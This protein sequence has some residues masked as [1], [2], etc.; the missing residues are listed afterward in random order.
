L[1]PFLR[2]C[3]LQMIEEEA[4][5]RARLAWL[6]GLVPLGG[7]GCVVLPFGGVVVV[8]GYVPTVPVIWVPADPAVVVEPGVAPQ[9]AGFVCTV[10]PDQPL[11]Y[12]NPPAPAPADAPAQPPAAEEVVL[13]PAEKQAFDEIV[14]TSQNPDVLKTMTPADVRKF[15]ADV[16]PAGLP[17][18]TAAE[19]DPAAK[20]GTL[21]P[22][23]KVPQ[24]S[25]YLRFANNSKE[26]VTL[27]VEVPAAPENKT[28]A[29]RQLEYKMEP[30]EVADLKDGDW[31]VNAS[32]V[33]FSVVTEKGKELNQ[34]KD[35]DFV[36]VPEKDEKGEPSYQA[37]TPEVAQIGIQGDESAG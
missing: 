5:A 30:G 4:A 37:A 15:L 13:T 8:P 6:N 2:L 32:K 24:T 10:V 7:P 27:K 22:D 25:R 14:K 3:I 28:E 11:E 12:I 26:R 9:G 16:Y 17:T 19:S 18:E 33:R 21:A 1:P 29:P 35:K 23:L 36:L 34:F 20:L 31:R